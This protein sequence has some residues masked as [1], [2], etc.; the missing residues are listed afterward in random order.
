ML[1]STVVAILLRSIIYQCFK[2]F[3]YI[4]FCYLFTLITEFCSQIWYHNVPHTKLAKIK[5]H[6]NWV[7]ATG[8]YLVFPGGGTQFKHGALHYI[9]FI[10]QVKNLITPSAFQSQTVTHMHIFMYCHTCMI[11]ITIIL[12]DV[13]F[14]V[15]SVYFVLAYRYMTNTIKTLR[16]SQKPLNGC[17]TFYTPLLARVDLRTNAIRVYN[18]TQ[19][20]THKQRVWRVQT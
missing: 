17:Y 4:L 7:K 18:L 16:C 3:L 5:G 2:F 14:V 19:D 6:Q 12:I 20:V 8:E 1:L 9:D 13:Q 10:Q 11:M 15:G